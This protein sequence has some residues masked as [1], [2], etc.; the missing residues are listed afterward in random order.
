V[1]SC[2]ILG[3]NSAHFLDFSAFQLFLIAAKGSFLQNLGYLST[4]GLSALFGYFMGFLGLYKLVQV[5]KVYCRVTDVPDQRF[6]AIR[7]PR[8]RHAAQARL[9]EAQNGSPPPPQVQG[10]TNTVG[11]LTHGTG[12]N[13]AVL[14]LT[15]V[16]LPAGRSNQLRISYHK[17]R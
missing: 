1:Q 9:S 7:M 12:K 16:T 11:P 5:K 4:F 15:G 6:S 10:S 13:T 2:A 3:S 8:P 14:R 17:C